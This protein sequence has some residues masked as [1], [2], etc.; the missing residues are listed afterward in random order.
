MVGAWR[1]YRGGMADEL[2]SAFTRPIDRALIT[3]KTYQVFDWHT[4]HRLTYTTVELSLG[5][6]G[7]QELSDDAALGRN[8]SAWLARNPQLADILAAEAALDA[9]A[10]RG[11]S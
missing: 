8:V 3:H 6:D 1:A 11:H 7:F 10:H 4:D 9:L 5:V 2:A